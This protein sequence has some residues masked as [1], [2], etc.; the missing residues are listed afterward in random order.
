MSDCKR[1]SSPQVFQKESILI[2]P[3]PFYGPALVTPTL[4][5]LGLGLRFIKQEK[6][7]HKERTSGLGLLLSL[8]KTSFPGI[9]QVR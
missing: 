3:L 2:V 1:A 5:G 7:R 8:C 4:K 9:C 6:P